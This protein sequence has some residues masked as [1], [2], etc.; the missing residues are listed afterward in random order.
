MINLIPNFEVRKLNIESDKITIKET[1]GLTLSWLGF[2]LNVSGIPY[3]FK[4]H[5]KENK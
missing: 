3:Y 5:I 2:G 1:P 4:K